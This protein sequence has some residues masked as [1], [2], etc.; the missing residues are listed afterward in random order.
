MGLR[1]AM[2]AM[3]KTGGNASAINWTYVHIEKIVETQQEEK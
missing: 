1:C 2:S 3:I